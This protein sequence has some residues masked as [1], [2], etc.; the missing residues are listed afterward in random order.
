MR[1]LVNATEI[2]HSLSSSIR[3]CCT[4]FVTPFFAVRFEL[5]LYHPIGQLSADASGLFLWSR[6]CCQVGPSHRFEWNADVS[7]VP[8]SHA[9]VVL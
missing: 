4:D 1:R 8:L 6:R 7:L 5:D 2:S 9:V 3:S